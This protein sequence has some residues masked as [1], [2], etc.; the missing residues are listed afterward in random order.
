MEYQLVNNNSSNP[1]SIDGAT[2]HV[3][4]NGISRRDY[5]ALAVDDS[6]IH[7]TQHV[8]GPRTV[9]D[10]LS[11]INEE[12][13]SAVNVVVDIRDILPGAGTCADL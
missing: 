5:T 1:A 8:N 9:H 3:T 6:D 13:N 10:E 12:S 7:Q 2:D 11:P 4:R